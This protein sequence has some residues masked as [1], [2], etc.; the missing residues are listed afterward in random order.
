MKL[1]LISLAI[2]ATGCV[3]PTD[4]NP[5]SWDTQTQTD[6]NT[7][8]NPAC[9]HHVARQNSQSWLLL[10]PNM[11]L[12]FWGDYWY[13]DTTFY[14]VTIQ[15]VWNY[16]FGNGQVL[17]RLSEYGISGGIIDPS[18]YVTNLDVMTKTLASLDDAGADGGP[19][20]D[21]SDAG[22]YN[23][24][25]GAVPFQYLKDEDIVSE[26]NSEIQLG[27]LPLPGIDN[28]LYTIVLP[29]AV[30]TV[31]MAKHDWYAYHASGSYGTMRY[32][33][34]VAQFSSDL[35]TV[36]GAISHELYEAATDPDGTTGYMDTDGSEVGDLC[37]GASDEMGGWQVQKVWSEQVCQCL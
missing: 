1:G 19:L 29:P 7:L 24:P 37:Q 26:I 9:P 10:H 20:T 15:G 27:Q 5:A 30:K 4:V 12:I 22:I 14:Y 23:G 13:N 32:A 35:S 6:A 2:L 3:D 16:L 8:G 31:N 18:V 17:Q 34:A 21:P 11:K 28:T 25:D 33:F 36:D